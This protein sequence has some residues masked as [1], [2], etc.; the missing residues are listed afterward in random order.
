MHAVVSHQV[1]MFHHLRFFIKCE[2]DSIIQTSI[3]RTGIG[4]NVSGG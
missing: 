4:Y 1:L 2:M 3:S